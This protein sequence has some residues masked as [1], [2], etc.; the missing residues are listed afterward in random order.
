MALPLNDRSVRRQLSNGGVGDI[1]FG[2]RSWVL[3]AGLCI[4]GLRYHQISGAFVDDRS[5]GGVVGR[6]LGFGLRFLW[7][8]PS[9]QRSV[10]HFDLM[11]EWGISN[12]VSGVAAC[13]LEA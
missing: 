12:V 1:Q 8:L 9:N 13:M 5:D 7:T 11:G 3:H 10:R 6:Q 2:F 4:F